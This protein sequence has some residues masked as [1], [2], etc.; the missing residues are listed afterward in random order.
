M[1]NI[2][3]ASATT[4][5][6][7]SGACVRW[8]VLG[9]EARDTKFTPS[10]QYCT[11]VITFTVLSSPNILKCNQ[12]DTILALRVHLPNGVM[13]LDIIVEL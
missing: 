13:L 11:G 5:T 7:E 12:H 10:H 1:Y 8:L 3:S 4:S 9:W 2:N 6:S